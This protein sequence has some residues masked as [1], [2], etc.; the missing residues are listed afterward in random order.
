[1]QAPTAG[2]VPVVVRNAFSV[3]PIVTLYTNADLPALAFNETVY[4]ATM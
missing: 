1:M 4:P 3:W 2:A